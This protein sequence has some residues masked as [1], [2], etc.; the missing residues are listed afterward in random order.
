MVAM[1]LGI[2]FPCICAVSFAVGV[3]AVRYTDTGKGSF[4]GMRCEL[5]QSAIDI[6][7][8]KMCWSSRWVRLTWPGQLELRPISLPSM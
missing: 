4:D 3:T 5:P 8:L 7:D 6:G 1:I 2:G